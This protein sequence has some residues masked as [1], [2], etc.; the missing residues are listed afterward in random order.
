MMF[1]KEINPNGHE[2]IEGVEFEEMMYMPHYFSADNNTIKSNPKVIAFSVNN[3]HL[4]FKTDNGVFSKNFLDRGTEVLLNFLEIE[5]NTNTVLDLGCGYGTIG[6]YIN[7]TY[8]ISV[9]MVDINQRA[10]DLSVHNVELNNTE[11]N[12]FKSDGFSNIKNKQGQLIKLIL[13][14]RVM[15]EGFSMK[16]VSSVFILD[17]SFTMG[18]IEQII[19]RAIRWCSHLK[20]MNKNNLYIGILTGT[21][22]DSIDCGIFDFDSRYK[23]TI[24]NDKVKINLATGSVAEYFG[25]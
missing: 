5:E 2:I 1:D 18:K 16:N 8:N 6:V 15:T 7:K 24:I 10:I 14:S 11:A 19:G 9:D 22:M 17:A 13:G 4:K 12:V 23:L 25:V 3:A 21:S 20:V